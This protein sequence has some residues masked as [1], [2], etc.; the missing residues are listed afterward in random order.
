MSNP[1]F[2]HPLGCCE[3]QIIGEGTKIWAFS[4]ILSGAVIGKDCNIC[5]HVFIENDVRI[6]DRVTIKCG[7]QIWDGIRIEDDVF[8]GPNVSFSNDPFPRSKK[9][10]EK[11]LETCIAKAASIGANATIL[12]GIKIGTLAMIGAGSVVTSDVPPRAIVTGNPARIT[13]YV[14]TPNFKPLESVGLIDK[15]LENNVVPVGVGNAALYKVPNYQDLRGELL[16]F[17]FNSLLPFI[18]KRQFVVYGVPSNKVRGEHAHYEC[19]QFLVALHGSLSVVVD[20]GYSARE[21]DL[22]SPQIGLFL[23]KLTWGTQYKFSK[24]AI[25][26]VLASY[27]YDAND[28]IREYDQFLDIVRQL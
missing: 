19:D 12:P 28:Y 22:D 18:P 23:P 8:I 14:D 13:G 1:F 9:Y 27:P 24:D 21:I 11:Y 15:V 7:V 26:M 6:G 2:V 17:E 4:H 5:D 20:D 10:P 25:L 3:S 16:V